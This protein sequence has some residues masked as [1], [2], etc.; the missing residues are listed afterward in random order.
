MQWAE[1]VNVLSTCSLNPILC[2]RKPIWISLSS[3]VRKRCYVQNNLTVWYEIIIWY[4]F[5]KWKRMK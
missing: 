2:N 3:G 4:L 1:W 5:E